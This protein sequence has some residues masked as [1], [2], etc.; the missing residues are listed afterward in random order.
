MNSLVSYY[1]YLD[2]RCIARIESDSLNH[3][4]AKAHE[5]GIEFGKHYNSITTVY[6]PEPRT[7]GEVLDDTLDGAKHIARTAIPAARRTL[8]NLFGFMSHSITPKAKTTPPLE[9]VR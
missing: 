7:A 6:Q 4:E 2:K 8:G 3:A 5:Q 1:L 9:I